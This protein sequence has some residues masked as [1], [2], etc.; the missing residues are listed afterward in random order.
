MTDLDTA[1]C[2]TRE[3]W[4]A[5]LQQQAAMLQVH[6]ESL[7]LQRLLAERLLGAGDA[8]SVSTQPERVAD[9]LAEVDTRLPPPVSLQPVT[10]TPLQTT[11]L[12]MSPA[13]DAAIEAASEIT[14]E[15][16]TEPEIT[17]TQAA[18]SNEVR[19][20]TSRVYSSR[21]ARYYQS[22]PSPDTPSIKPEDLELMRRLQEMRET[23]G[24]ILQFGPY[25]GT[26]LAQ[27]TVRHPEY[28]RQ[29]MLSAQRPEVRAAAGRLVAALD[30][31]AEHKRHTARP[32][33][34]GRPTA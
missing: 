15:A 27:V 2:E 14:P 11:G 26:T 23:G 19:P 18:P 33:R 10:P 1:D 4:H 32:N 24:L 22:H 16:V 3:L 21:V 29:L 13:S 6:A 17:S 25:K 7:R 12:N 5:M 34:R 8:E 31:A 30:A 20:S 28:I 9:P